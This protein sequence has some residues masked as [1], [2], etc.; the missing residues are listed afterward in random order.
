MSSSSVRTALWCVTSAVL[1]SAHAAQAQST[2]PATRS[3]SAPHA[4]APATNPGRTFDDYRRY[5][6]D[7]PMLGWRDAN[8]RVARLG[9]WRR[10]A[11]EVGTEAPAAASPAAAAA[12]SRP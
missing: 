9:G 1:W 2:A 4:A 12:G 10:Y 6:A 7:E 5:R 11:R 3:A 8:D